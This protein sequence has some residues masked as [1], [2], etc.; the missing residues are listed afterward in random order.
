[1]DDKNAMEKLN[2]L[3]VS[4]NN[5]ESYE[6]RTAD[7]RERAKENAIKTAKENARKLS[8]K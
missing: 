4:Y 7:A 5:G 8:I 2:D 1:M 3:L 6:K